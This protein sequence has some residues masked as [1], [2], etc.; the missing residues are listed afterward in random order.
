MCDK[1]CD[2]GC[3]CESEVKI[4]RSITSHNNSIGRDGEST[5]EI[6]IRIGSFTG[7]ES[8]YIIWNKGAKGD[9]GLI[10]NTGATGDT[11]LQGVAGGIGQTGVVGQTGAVGGQGLP[12]TNGLPGTPGVIGNTGP[13]GP[14]GR[15]SQ[16]F[17]SSADP[18]IGNTVYSGDF[19]IVI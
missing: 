9:N 3:G 18:S 13:V 12:G 15:T 1:S 10:G 5:Y 2:G 6:A 7:T 8:E 16:V 19:W 4:T 14:N 11:G 17:Q